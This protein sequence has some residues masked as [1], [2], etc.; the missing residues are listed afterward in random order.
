MTVATFVAIRNVKQTRGAMLGAMQYVSQD[1]KTLWHGVSLL[2]GHNCVPQSSYIEFLTTKK[3]FHKTDGR[4]FYHFVQ[5]FAEGDRLSPRLANAIGA[6]L[7]EKGFPDFEVLVATH[8]D[9]GH[10]HNHL[11]VNSVSCIDGKK[12]HQNSQDL[13]H[14]RDVNDQICMKYHLSVLPKPQKHSRKKRMVPGEYQAGLRGQSWKLELVLVLNQALC[15]AE[16][17]ESFIEYLEREGY[18]VKWSANR[19]HITF[20]TPEGYRCRDSSLHDETLL[21]DNLEWLFLYR[22]L[23]GFDFWSV[24]PADGWLSEVSYNAEA[25]TRYMAQA[26]DA[27]DPPPIPVW[28]ES[29]QRQREALKKLAHGQRLENIESFEEDEGYSFGMSM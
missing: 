1:K 23:Y 22:Q 19:K 6:E 3:R 16:D 5:S 20:I 29:K 11:I 15:E 8:V 18:Q 2:G 21:K 28:T 4:Q 25:L 9:T 27:P 13:Q 17:K 24:E 7:A 12:L 14:H 10:L 26:M